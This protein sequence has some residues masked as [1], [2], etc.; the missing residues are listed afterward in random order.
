M[1]GVTVLH[2]WRAALPLT[3]G[4]VEAAFADY[5]FLLLIFF[6]EAHFIL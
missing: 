2:G 1:T 5:Y 6:F 3:A 4:D